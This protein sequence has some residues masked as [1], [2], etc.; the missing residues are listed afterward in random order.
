MQ[1]VKSAEAKLIQPTTLSELIPELEKCG[2]SVSHARTD[3]TGTKEYIF[4]RN[5]RYN[6]SRNNYGSN[7]NA[8]LQKLVNNMATQISDLTRRII[9]LERKS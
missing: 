5:Q 8:E 2:Y 6:Q 3:R 7:T 4:K 9:E 1:W